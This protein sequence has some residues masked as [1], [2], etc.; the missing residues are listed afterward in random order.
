MNARNVIATYVASARRLYTSPANQSTHYGFRLARTHLDQQGAGT[1]SNIF[2]RLIGERGITN[3]V[4]LNGFAKGNIFCNVGWGGTQ[5]HMNG[6]DSAIRGR[7]GCPG[8][9]YRHGSMSRL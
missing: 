1:D 8:P 9:G 7:L 3:E 6:E 4:R 5:K 2:V